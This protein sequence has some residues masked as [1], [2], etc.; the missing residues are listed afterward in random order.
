MLLIAGKRY[1]E[2]TQRGTVRK[3]APQGSFE[4]RQNRREFVRSYNQRNRE[5]LKQKELITLYG[6][7]VVNASGT[8]PLLCQICNKPEK[9]KHRISGNVIALALDHDHKT[10]KFR[11]WLCSNC[12]TTLGRFGDDPVVF[13]RI[14]HYLE[15]SFDANS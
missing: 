1:G 3:R 10:G 4:A 14:A 6:E 15:G 11:G 12:N 5:H 8:S 9:V 2:L 13:R 7:D